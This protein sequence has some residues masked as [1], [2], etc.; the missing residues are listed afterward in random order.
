MAWPPPVAPTR[1][2]T[3][4][5]ENKWSLLRYRPSAP[6]AAATPVLL[7]PSLINRHFVLDLIRGRSLV[8]YLVDRGHPVYCVAWGAPGDEDR[9][10]SLD[11]IVAGY[12]G[13]A[14]RRTAADART[15]GVHLLGYCLGGTLTAAYT[16]AFPERV[17]TLTA[18]AAPVD[19][20]R[21]GIMTDWVRTESFDLDAQRAIGNLPWPLM[22]AAFHCLRPT[23]KIAKLVLALRRAGDDDFL[24]SFMALERWGTDNV[25]FPGDAYHRYIKD[26]YR[27]NELVT[28]EMAIAGRRVDL[29]SIR[30]P[31]HVV[32]F[33]GDH[34]VPEQSALALADRVASE[35]VSIWCKPGGHVS[36][37]IAR[38]AATD[39]WPALSGFWLE[40]DCLNRRQPVAT[41]AAS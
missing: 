8:E 26:M 12:V 11:E 5:R 25:S 7:V 28:G 1:A 24:A 10:L 21:A 22:Q 30:C 23:L 40:R 35:D 13:R 2:D 18:M 29:G 27:R 38:S 9:Y 36:T 4:W 16:A 33:E 31:L 15:G 14:V 3:I 6:S 37:V 39:L 17:E 32:A 34:I 19:F 20:D 41:R